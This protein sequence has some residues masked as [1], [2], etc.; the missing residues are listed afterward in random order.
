MNVSIYIENSLDRQL[1]ESANA[2]H[3]TRNAI[4]REAIQEWLEH[5]H[6]VHEWPV[7]ILNFKGIKGVKTPRFESLRRELTEPK[8]DPC[9]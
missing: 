7:C 3:K 2:L 8:D 1:R 6:K 5:H 9:K 4:I